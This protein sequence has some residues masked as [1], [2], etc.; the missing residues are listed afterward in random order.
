MIVAQSH[1]GPLLT[2]RMNFKVDEPFNQAN[3]DHTQVNDIQIG[4][5]IAGIVLLAIFAL[6][7][8]GG[9]GGAALPYFSRE[10][11][12]SEGERAFYDVLRTSIPDG[13]AISM[14]VRLADVI[15][16]SPAARQKGYFAKVSQKHLDFV[17]YD[18]VSTR[19]LAGVELD[20]RS[21]Q[22]PDRIRRD[23]FLEEAMSTA[24]IPLLRIPAAS[25]YDGR[26]LRELVI[27]QT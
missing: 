22:R 16:C 1:C 18:V 9:A 8:L 24:G 25:S 4:L 27:Y 5:L 10:T 12:L 14:K 21:H 3:A 20:D 26:K 19:I 13:V 17:L 11:L 15:D 2:G 23:Q 6:I 7:F